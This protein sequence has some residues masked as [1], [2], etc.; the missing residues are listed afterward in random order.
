MP[1][2]SLA[3]TA[4]DISVKCWL[5]WNDFGSVC[6]PVACEIDATFSI[7]IWYVAAKIDGYEDGAFQ[8]H[9]AKTIEGLFGH[10]QLHVVNWKKFL[11]GLTDDTGCGHNPQAVEDAIRRK[12]NDFAKEETSHKH[13]P[14]A[15]ATHYPPLKGPGTMPEP[16][17]GR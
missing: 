8:P 17:G 3:V 10:E 16:H 9:P 2:N 14:P 5:D 1:R 15:N 4:R 7:H 13:V 6:C 12:I 11:Q